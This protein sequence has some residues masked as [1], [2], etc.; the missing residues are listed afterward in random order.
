MA[1][2]LNGS[3]SG[4]VELDVPA[5]AGSHTL[6]LPDGGGTS[7]QYLQTN[8]SGVLSW[9]TVSTRTI[10]HD[11]ASLSGSSSYTFDSIP[12]NV[13][14]IHLAFNSLSTTDNVGLRCLI[15]DSGGVESAGY[16]Q[17]QFYAGSLSGGS[18][19]S[20]VTKWYN[21]ITHVLASDSLSGVLHLYNITG[22]TWEIDW[23][24]QD[25]NNT[26]VGAFVIGWK[27]LSA[28]LDRVQLAPDGAGTFD[29]GTL[30]IHYIH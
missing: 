2:R 22:N 9:Q 8:G 15:G 19:N 28:T 17:T 4:Y 13:K 6:T 18:R 23:R 14:A 30:S 20:N 10:Y 3:S 5:A 24:Y 25:L 26:A 12:S 27:T 11:S 1:L 21:N 7:G 29:G 16:Y